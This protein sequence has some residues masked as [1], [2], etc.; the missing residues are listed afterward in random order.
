MTNHQQRESRLCSGLQDLTMQYAGHD[1]R[2][3]R[4]LESC[5]GRRGCQGCDQRRA[6]DAMMSCRLYDRFRR[7]ELLYSTRLRSLRPEL[8][9]ATGRTLLVAAF[10]GHIAGLGLVFAVEEFGHAGL[11]KDR[12]ECISNDFCDRKHLDLVE[13][14]LSC[15]GQCV[16]ENHS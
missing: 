2:P 14:L 8:A 5:H 13:L 4:R 9:T 7:R 6:S 11:V 10:S 16:C 15:Q 12:S 1:V 3:T